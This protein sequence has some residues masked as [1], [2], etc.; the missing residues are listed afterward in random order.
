MQPPK[1]DLAPVTVFWFL[2]LVVP[3]LVCLD[4]NQTTLYMI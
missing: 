3:D 1:S 2:F 4:A